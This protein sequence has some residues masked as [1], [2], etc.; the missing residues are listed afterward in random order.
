ME[1]PLSSLSFKA[2]LQEAATSR[3]RFTKNFRGTQQNS[4]RGWAVTPRDKDMTKGKVT[5][6]M[7]TSRDHP[8]HGLIAR[9]AKNQEITKLIKKE[10]IDI[11]SFPDSDG[12]IAIHIAVQ[13][14]F[15]EI[16]VLLVEKYHVAIDR[17]DNFGNTP[18]HLAANNND[19][20][21]CE[22]LILNGANST[23][24]NQK[25]GNIVHILS[26][27]PYEKEYFNAVMNIIQLV[28][29]SGL[30]INQLNKDGYAPLHI[31][32]Q[33]GNTSMILL[34]LDYNAFIEILSEKEAFTPLQ[35]ACFA[36][37]KSAIRLLRSKGASL[38]CFTA[39]QVNQLPAEIQQ[40]FS[41]GGIEPRGTASP[42][43]LI[44]H[45]H[46]STCLGNKQEVKKILKKHPRLICS[47]DKAG[48]TVL[49]IAACLNHQELV[50]LFLE[51]GADP[52]I[53]NDLGLTSLLSAS[54]SGFLGVFF[55]FLFFLFFF[56]IKFLFF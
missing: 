34:L 7:F 45:F 4:N 12:K 8:I 19:L 22:Y 1:L 13:L 24:Q 36:S 44:N 47:I 40:L 6:E 49:H 21:L 10:G 32:A 51:K 27:F 5:T 31:A 52:N 43:H 30:N 25:D 53:P 28:K 17:K 37:Q 26:K 56:C 48:F 50:E 41:T 2:S 9:R 38:D 11:L 15:T 33:L 18:L 39:E 20:K 23:I 54:K 29:Q 42:D 46:S 3:S 55:S 14:K 35:I 16:I